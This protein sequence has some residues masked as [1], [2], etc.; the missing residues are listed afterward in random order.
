MASLVLPDSSFYIRA[1][2]AGRNPLQELGVRSDDYEFAVC[3]VVQVE[4]LRGRRDPRV[5]QRFRDAFAAMLFINTT[6]GVW[7]RAADLAWRLDRQ[8]LVIPATDLVIAACALETKAAVLTH[9]AH[10]HNVPGL[11]VVDRLA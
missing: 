6:S 10:F 4:I 5:W 8:G 2:C 1:M 9:D 3:G 11:E 7:Q